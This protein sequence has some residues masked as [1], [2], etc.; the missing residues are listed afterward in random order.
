MV[1][2]IGTSAKHKYLVD[3]LNYLPI[4]YWVMETKKMKENVVF[5]N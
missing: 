3:L 5:E 1:V 4:R 2:C